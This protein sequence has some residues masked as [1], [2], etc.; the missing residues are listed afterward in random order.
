MIFPGLSRRAN[1]SDE[2][3]M[4]KRVAAEALR[5]VWGVGGMLLHGKEFREVESGGRGLLRGKNYK[6]KGSSEDCGSLVDVLGEKHCRRSQKVRRI[7]KTGLQHKGQVSM[8][9]S[10][11]VF[12]YRR[13]GE[14]LF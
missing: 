5:W 11:E 4:G 9:F 1:G 14:T 13:N 7:W 12:L 6:K 8:G 3:I 10:C 2:Q